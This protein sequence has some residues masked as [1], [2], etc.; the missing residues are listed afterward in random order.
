MDDLSVS[1]MP[2]THSLDQL[3]IVNRCLGGYSAT[4][5]ALIPF[6]RNHAGR[7]VRILDVG[8]GAA[9]FPE[10]IVRWSVLGAP[11]V[12]LSVTAV[13]ANPAS[14]AYAGANLTRRLPPGLAAKICVEHADAL[15]LPY[16]DHGFDIA[17][18]AMF[19]HH[20]PAD[21]AITVL[22]EMRRVA[23][24]GVIIN[25][26]QRHPLAYFGIAAL[27][28]ALPA[29]PMVR[30]DGP[31]SVLRGFTRTELAEIATSAGIRNFTLR[32]RWAFRWVL[33]CVENGE[34]CATMRS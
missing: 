12:D 2:L 31:L 10:M 34:P 14:V 21:Q 6:L 27:T 17:I 28:R 4:L 1:G 16:P 33:S 18:A 30:H 15:A 24:C 8:T 25:D 7:S 26:L 23:R 32:W 5:S 11:T 19:L 29:S 13:D 3:R 9:D 22:R 20:F